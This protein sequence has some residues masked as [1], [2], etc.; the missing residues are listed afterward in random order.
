MGS[1]LGAEGRLSAKEAVLGA[2]GNPTQASVATDTSNE[3]SGHAILSRHG[4]VICN[5][6]GT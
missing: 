3:V 4:N 2:P 1:E 5:N 6:V